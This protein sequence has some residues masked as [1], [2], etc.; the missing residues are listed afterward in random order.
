MSYP[1]NEPS[2]SDYDDG[3]TEHHYTNKCVYEQS[4]L[5]NGE[6]LLEQDCYCHQRTDAKETHYNSNCHWVFERYYKSGNGKVYVLQKA[7][8]CGGRPQWN[9]PY[10]PSNE[11]SRR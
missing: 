2:R 6:Y 8:Y 11:T 7:C 5:G 9:S 10:M 4:Y 1:W 3:K